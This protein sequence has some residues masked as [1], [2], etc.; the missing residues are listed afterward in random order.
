MDIEVILVN[1]F[2][3]NGAGGN[4]AGVVLNADVLSDEQKLSIAQAVGYSETAFVCHDDDVGFEVSFFTT[5]GE[6]D[7]CGH[8]TLAVF[9]TLFQERIVVAGRYTQKT[10]A[11]LLAVVVEPTG[12]VTMDLQLPQKLGKFTHQ[13]ISDVIGI[14]S[15]ILATTQLPIEVISTGLADVIIPVPAGYLDSII[16]NDAAIAD[17]CHKHDVVGFHVFEL[18]GSGSEITACCRNFAPLFGIPEE[19][20]TGSAT[21]ALACYFAEHLPLDYHYVVEQGR[22]MGCASMLTA[23]VELSGSKITSVKVG[24]TASRIGTTLYSFC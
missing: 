17:F 3:S 7:F 12:H 5:T 20:A 13:D 24:G 22:A 21:G 10:K 9:S 19:S 4:P 18:C 6:V 8:A 11:G 2:T 16:P 14:D 23:S 1:S 15:A